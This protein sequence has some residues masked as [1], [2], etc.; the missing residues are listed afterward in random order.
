VIAAVEGVAF[1]GGLHIAL[2]ADIRI[3]APDARL[4]FVET[5][6]GLVPD[7]SGTQSLRRLVSLDVAKKLIYTGREINGVEAVELGLGTELSDT[8]VEDALAMAREIAGRSP[9]AIRA[10]KRLL[11][12]SGL[13]PLAEGLANEFRL[14]SSLMGTPN[15]VEAVMAR[16]QKRDPD[17]GDPLS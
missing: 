11:N 1:G 6:W 4:A 17:Y 3:M 9:D 8:P 2:A 10:A 14:S 7:L 16:L 12:D 5:S 15:Q 13:V